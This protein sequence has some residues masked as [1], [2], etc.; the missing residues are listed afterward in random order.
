MATPS[1]RARFAQFAPGEALISDWLTTEVS[2]ALSSKVRTGALT[3]SRRAVALTAYQRMF[4]DDLIVLPV[5]ASDFR[6]AARIAD[7][8]DL[9]LRASDAL[10]LAIATNHRA[11]LLTLDRRL[12]A[13][14]LALGYAME[15]V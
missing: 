3:P 12:H 1:I 5:T 13:A 4:L 15:T 2:S 10:H 7:R 9:G 14:G 8:Y 11:T 6:E